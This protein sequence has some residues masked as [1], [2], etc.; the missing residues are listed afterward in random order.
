MKIDWQTVHEKAAADYDL[1]ALEA[2]RAK[3]SPSL[4]KALR[5]LADKYHAAAERERKRKEAAKRTPKK[6]PRA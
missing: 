4:I 3:R 1:K 6:H 5:Q 2:A